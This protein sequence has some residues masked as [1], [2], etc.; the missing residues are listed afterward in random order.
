MVAD[1]AQL[2]AQGWL[3]H[4]LKAL[5]ACQ[6]TDTEPWM[7]RIATPYAATRVR[8]GINLKA[9]LLTLIRNRDGV[10]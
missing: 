8:P 3:D 5:A 10:C 1:H 4:G 9:P 7:A 2:S 6:K